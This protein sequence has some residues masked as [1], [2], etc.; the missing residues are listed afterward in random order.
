MEPQAP[1]NIKLSLC[2][3]VKDEE[4]TLAD[5]LKSVRAIVDEIVV[6]DTGSSDSTVQV[7][8][9]FG[10]RVI[11][12][13]W[14]E[15]FAEARNISLDA[16]TGN[17]IIV[18]DADEEM[19][20][21]S[22]GAIDGLL[23][24]NPADG[25]EVTIRNELPRSDVATYEE[26]RIVRLFRNRREYRYRK[27]IHEQ[28][29]MSIESGG[30]RIAPS[31][32]VI[33]HH[34]YARRE[35]QSGVDRSARNLNM[36]RKALKDSPEDPYLHFQIG[37]TLMSI[38]KRDEARMEFD[39]VLELDYGSLGPAVLDKFYMKISQLAL[40]NNEYDRALKFAGESLRYNGQN[41]ISEYVA[42]IA[43][44]ST[45]RIQEGYGYLLRVRDNPKDSLR[46]KS[47]LSE[48]I[49]ACEKALGHLPG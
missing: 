16:A 35:V 27:S 47:Q 40:E 42:A 33:V 24:S 19:D 17:W 8:N 20:E 12:H 7:A 4:S 9:Q 48:L 49:I 3:I 22:R 39:S 29:R 45:N 13:V 28:I 44:L 10:A 41:S 11:P 37:S 18:L 32:L 23:E 25:Y 43:C 6:V 2:M 34:G 1:V 26:S 5:C 14:K 36:L 21:I 30:G 31:S 46:L 15:D 38:G